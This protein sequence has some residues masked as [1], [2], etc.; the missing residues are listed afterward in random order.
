M[1]NLRRKKSSKTM[2]IVS[3][4]SLDLPAIR[5]RLIP[6]IDIALRN[7]FKITLISPTDSD[8][9]I[10]H[11]NLEILSINKKIE[12]SSS[13][14]LRAIGEIFSSFRMIKLVYKNNYD[15][16]IIGIPSIFNLL[17]IKPILNPQF[18]DIR[19]IAWEYLRDDHF[20][21]SVV[22]LIFRKVAKY[23]FRI[24]NLVLTTNAAESDYVKNFCG[25][26]DNKVYLLSN[27]IDEKKFNKIKLINNKFSKD[28]EVII[29]Y[30]GNIGVAQ[31][32]ETIL[33][34]A[35]K[36]KYIKFN[37]VGSGRDFKNV[38]NK[39]QY[40][41]L[42]N[43]KLHGRVNWENIIKIYQDTDIL[44]A[45]LTKNFSSAIPSKLYEYLAS[46]KC[47][48]YGG[49]GQAVEKL[50]FFENVFFVE[51]Q[52]NITLTKCIEN[53]IQNN[54]H[55]KISLKN[56]KTIQKYYI[57]EKNINTFFEKNIT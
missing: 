33:L 44:Y 9:G 54:H 34:A 57:R 16:V 1:E 10:K 15:Y 45:Q 21:E 41:N 28:K 19:D 27:G 25:L 24:F 55:K 2:A 49:I 29:S 5:N 38:K 6:F 22:K 47:I 17:F 3:G 32:L 39:I 52:N 18:L 4:Y 36:L 51:P 37:I 46:G 13:Y 43:V 14:F 31:N 7:K 35:R 23:K 53:I 8:L 20:L 12:N 40:Y 42:D 11:K 30:I 48:I 56:K 26:P 50:K